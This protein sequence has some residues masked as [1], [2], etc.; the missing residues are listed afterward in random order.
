MN[1][2]KNIHIDEHGAQLLS[3]LIGGLGG[4]D[5]DQLDE[6]NLESSSF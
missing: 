2:K 6:Y 3:K 4:V 5:T 1:Q